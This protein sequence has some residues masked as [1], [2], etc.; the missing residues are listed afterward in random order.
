VYKVKNP[1]PIFKLKLATTY[2]SGMQKE[3]KG[4]N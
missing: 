3:D 2:N 1:S 4:V